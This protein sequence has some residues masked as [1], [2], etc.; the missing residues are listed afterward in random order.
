MAQEPTDATSV[1]GLNPD[2]PGIGLL[3]EAV[4][5]ADPREILL[6]C[7]GDL[8]GVSAPATRLFSDIREQVGAHA[9]AIPMALDPPAPAD[10]SFHHAIVWPRSHLGKDFTFACLARGALALAPGGTLWC[11]ARKAKGAS[12][13]T[14]EIATLMGEVDVVDRSRGYRL[15]SARRGDRFNEEHALSRLS[16]RYVIEHPALPGLT[17]HTCPGVFSRK[18]L[19]AG[20]AQLI[21]FARSH[22]PA[23][24]HVLDLCC[25]VGPL[26]LWAAGQWPQAQVL[27]IDSNVLATDQAR[28]NA[29]RHKLADRVFVHCGD[30]LSD[31]P[32]RAQAF[33]ERIDLALVNPPTHA[34]PAT[35]AVLSQQLRAWLAP[36]GTALFVVNRAGRMRDQLVATGATVAVHEAERYCVLRAQWNK[37]TQ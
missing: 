32:S 34:D 22:E 18:Q 37:A 19:D 13:I 15:L 9:M 25:G 1:E 11:A 28:A 2:D 26:A 10:A 3:A 35:L 12:S 36:N 7:S 5:R 4:A 23:P 24:R 16:A 8:P 20:T 31:P 27:A 17:L 6:V 29:E 14:D 30:G 33:R 21:E